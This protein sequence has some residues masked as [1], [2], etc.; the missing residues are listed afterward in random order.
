VNGG[1]AD[2]KTC[3]APLDFLRKKRTVTFIQGDT[4]TGNS[5][6]L[7]EWIIK[8]EEKKRRVEKERKRREERKEKEKYPTC[9]QRLF[10]QHIMLSRM[11]YSKAAPLGI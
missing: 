8:K 11:F 10:S 5:K 9:I 6:V 1:R 4:A 7:M 3:I 2:P